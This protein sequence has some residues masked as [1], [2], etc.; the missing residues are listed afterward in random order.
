MQD[1]DDDDNAVDDDDDDDK[2]GDDDDDADGDDAE[3]DDDDADVDE[4]DVV[5][6]DE[7]DG[8]DD[9]YDEGAYCQCDDGHPPACWRMPPVVMVLMVAMMADDG[10]CEDDGEGYGADG[11]DDACQDDDGN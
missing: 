6:D 7:D 8:D 9:Y 10:E 2:D 5:D 4:D 11:G 1:V 3:D